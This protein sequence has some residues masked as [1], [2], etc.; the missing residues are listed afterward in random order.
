MVSP[1]LRHAVPLP[2]PIDYTRV[3]HVLAIEIVATLTLW[4]LPALLLPPSWFP[5]FGIPESTIEH[6][7]FVRL[8]GASL[9]ALAVGYTLAWRTPARHPVAILV[10]IVSNGLAPLVIVS[11]GAGGGLATWTTVG[12]LYV[13]GSAVLMASLAVALT[14]TGQPLLRRLVERPRPGSV[15]V[16]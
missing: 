15:K 9:M 12:S 5:T 14:I 4:A 3:R 8:W 2:T 11:A 1:R 7:L 13:W 6:L 16:M 10:G